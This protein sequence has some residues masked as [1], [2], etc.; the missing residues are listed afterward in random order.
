MSN[1][2]SNQEVIDAFFASLPHQA[3]DPG[4]NPLITLYLTTG[5][6][7]QAE[8]LAYNDIWIYV[9]LPGAGN[10]KRMYSTSNIVY[11]TA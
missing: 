5:E 10:I 8:L 1:T 7:L 2:M 11:V 9:H 6:H 4:G 3:S